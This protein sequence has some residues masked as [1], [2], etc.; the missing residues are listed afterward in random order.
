MFYYFQQIYREEEKAMKGFLFKAICPSCAYYITFNYFQCEGN[1]P[2]EP[3]KMIQ[4][5]K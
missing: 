4:M 5:L 2:S 1:S 3:F